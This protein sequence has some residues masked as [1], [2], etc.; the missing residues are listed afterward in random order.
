M[1]QRYNPGK[2]GHHRDAPSLSSTAGY[3]HTWNRSLTTE[4]EGVDSL[5]VAVRRRHHDRSVRYGHG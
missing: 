4:P 5:S 2:N 3:G 1:I